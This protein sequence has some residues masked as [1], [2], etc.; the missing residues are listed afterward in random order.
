MSR[1]KISS[2]V[3]ALVGALA[4]S[5][6]GSHGT[7]DRNTT[8]PATGPAAG[9]TGS[10]SDAGA[11]QASLPPGAQPGVDDYDGDG[12]P[13]PTCE[14]QDFGGGLVLR[15]PCQIGNANGPEDGT[16]LVNRSLYRL[17]SYNTDLTG[18]SGS[19]VTAR[20]T[21]GKKVVIVVFNSD[22]LFE[23]GSDQVTEANTLDATIRLIN[24]QFSGAAVQVR[25]HT[26]GTGTASAN[27][28]LSERRAATVQ[29]YLTGHGVKASGVTAI[30]FGSSRP[31]VE[32]TNADGS[33]STAGRAFNRR[34]ELVLRLP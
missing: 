27:Q 33:A 18:I 19:L 7:D 28:A 14:T 5:A 23:T 15:V 20:D 2:V 17:P 30:G 16:R 4:L 32:E 11:P 10:P 1:F 34:V 6:C 26:D 31:L 9:G 25:G 3:V 22:N 21:A 8:A 12:T 24:G 13:D 29:K